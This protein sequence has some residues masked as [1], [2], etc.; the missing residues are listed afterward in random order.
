MDSSSNNNNN[1]SL[2][3][4]N[5]DGFFSRISS[6][7][8]QYLS[9]IALTTRFFFLLCVSLFILECFNIIKAWQVCLSPY[10]LL[11]HPLS[12]AYTIITSNY[13]HI[14]ILHILFNMLAFIPLGSR[15]EKSKFGTL[16]F[17]Y[18]IVL[19]SILIPLMTTVLSVIGLYTN[20]TRFG[21]YS[22]SVGFSGIVFSL[23]EIEFFE[24]RLVSLYGIT[25]IPSKLYPFAILFITY[26]IFPSS[27]F[28][29]HLSGIFVGL[30][31]VKGNL[32]FLFLS[33][34][35][36][37]QIETSEKLNRVISLQGYITNLNYGSTSSFYNN[38]SGGSVGSSSSSPSL[39]SSFTRIKNYFSRN[40]GGVQLGSISPEQ[41]RQQQ[42]QQQQQQ[43]PQQQQTQLTSPPNQ[44]PQQS[45]N[46]IDEDNN[47]GYQIPMYPP[48]S[49]QYSP[50][51]DMSEEN[52]TKN[53][54][55]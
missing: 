46:N 1:N 45:I 31:F 47:N 7:V 15:L 26:L 21:Y 38:S 53:N 9:T 52:Q 30:L 3:M 4:N 6:K 13:F 5:G 2:E 11:S 39:N 18:L 49:L 51:I 24:D 20:I 12:N 34:E 16:Q 35:K 33:P 37:V 28:L 36:Y 50:L 10:Y 44:Q 17:F 40:T 29:G 43:Q 54:N 55:K 8:N 27:S 22:C 23:L 41:F 19:F 14:N 25:N 48:T 42:M 32:S